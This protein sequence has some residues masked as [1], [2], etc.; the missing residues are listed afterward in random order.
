MLVL[1]KNRQEEKDM[2]E[3]MD[4]PESD[5]M[6]DS[7]E[8]IGSSEGNRVYSIEGGQKL[9]KVSWARF[10][11][12][13]ELPEDAVIVPL[14]SASG[15]ESE[16]VLH[17]TLKFYHYKL[18]ILATPEEHLEELFQENRDYLLKVV[19]FSLFDVE[20]PPEGLQRYQ[21]LKEAMGGAN[22]AVLLS[23][24]GDKE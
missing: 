19:F 17:D 20:I 23:F 2:Q 13:A 12:R 1:L 21:E 5:F 15:D 14:R 10:I 22:K 11:T 3:P 9:W 16:K 6:R 7:M 24:L 18:G 8:D 4:L